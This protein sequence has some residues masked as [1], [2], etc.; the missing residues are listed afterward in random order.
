MDAQAFRVDIIRPALKVT[1]LWSES[2]ENLLLGTALA[3]SNLDVV[4]QIGG[5]PALSFFQIEPATYADIMSYLSR[6]RDLKDKIMSA[7]YVDIMPDS[8]CLTWNIRLAALVARL[9][10][11]RQPDPLP[12]PDDA[13]GMASYWK[14]HYNTEQ[15]SGTEQHFI[16]Q[17][18]YHGVS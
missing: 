7:L 5:G 10:Y 6:R 16:D 11:W 9:I 15:G 14:I 3:E 1:D 18:N 8:S 12:S 2:A 17:W 4:K 13:V